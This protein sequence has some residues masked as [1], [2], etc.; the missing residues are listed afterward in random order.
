VKKQLIITALICMIMTPAFADEE[1]AKTI[2]SIT[3]QPDLDVQRQIYESPL[4]QMPGMSVDETKNQDYDAQNT[5]EVS[6][7]NKPPYG[8]NM[9]MFKQARIRITNFF[10]QK[11]LNKMK[12]EQDGTVKK[13]N[14]LSKLFKDNSVTLTDDNSEEM[15]NAV[16]AA[17]STSADTKSN[18]QLAGGVKEH[19]TT[20]DV[21]LDA[22]NVD[23]NDK[24]MDVV[25]TGHPVLNFPPQNTII[26]ADKIV[27][28]N[29]TNILKAYDNV[30]LIKDG[31]SIY[32]DF[33]Q[34]NMNEE[35]ALADNMKTTKGEL[36]IHAKHATADD[37]VIVLNDGTLS[38]SKDFVFRMETSMV[39]GFD[40]KQMIIDESDKSYISDI[41]GSKDI[42]VEVK[43]ITLDAKK[44][45][46]VTTFKE[47][48]V[49][50]GKKHLFDLPSFQAHTNKDHNYFEGDY[51]ELGSRNPMGMYFGPGY[52]FDLP[53]GSTLKAVPLVNY[54]SKF[55][56]GGAL[57]YKSATNMTDFMYGSANDVFVLKGKQYL[58][59][60]LYL[61]Y[62]MNAFLDEWFLGARMPKYAIEAVYE[63]GK[64]IP[65]TIGKGLGLQFKNRFSA[66][67]F[68]DTK[69]QLKDENLAQ[70]KDA[71]TR[72]RYMAEMSQSLY[73][74]EDIPNRKILDLS[75]VMQGSAAVYGTGDTQ[76]IGRVG[77]MLHTQYKYWMQN[78]GYF[79]SA[80][81]DQTPLLRYDT[82]RY[83]HSNVYL[84]EALRINKWLA[85]GWT[86]SANLLKEAP[87]GKLLQENGFIFS[88]GPDD[89]KVNLGYDF[90]REATYF[91]ITMAM[92]VKNSNVHFE[93]MVIKNPDRLTGDKKPELTLLPKPE[94][95]QPSEQNKVTVPKQYA[96]VID[97]Q[98]PERE[99][100]Q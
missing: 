57:K 44:Q 87:N 7:A 66:G 74:Y 80:Y 24:T 99:Y 3:A 79:A 56:I 48:E 9:P 29:V 27:Y 71:T 34:I 65:N 21:I 23:F 68:G 73:H 28:N 49:Y 94:D 78:V 60:K 81:Q 40:Y 100:V 4:T 30:E 89:L 88:I 83:G 51:P 59:D 77:P 62:G 95:F 13:H 86:I 1:S 38:A 31:S 72:L 32:G 61:Q 43:D 92:N 98:D 76:F 46:N 50:N 55:G 15:V 8:K 20:N 58:D 6:I 5:G 85:V 19:V 47:I 22:D 70:G 54:K 75:M 2:K 25:A 64:Y 33:M 11:S 67:Y 90:I 16:A 35:N 41:S 10:R 82:Y 18:L 84:N 39:G 12:A 36:E 97:I 53:N 45:H 69:Y 52:V 42:H 96:Q 37:K 91:N 63:D 14:K 17:D 26:K 93:K